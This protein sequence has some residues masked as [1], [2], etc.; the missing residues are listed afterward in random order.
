MNDQAIPYRYDSP[1][2]EGR[3]WTG[4]YAKYLETHWWSLVR[5][6]VFGLRG[7]VCERCGWK[8]GQTI[9]RVLDVHHLT[10]DRLGDELTVDLLILCS[11]CHGAE[12]GEAPR[13]I[14]PSGVSPIQS[15]LFEAL[16]K[17]DQRLRRWRS[18][19]D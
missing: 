5:V 6:T 15:H 12:H 9:D 2:W 8:W 18:T 4:P 1:H 13:Q 7:R 10:Y 11:V 14:M 16:I 19:H 3:K 17:V